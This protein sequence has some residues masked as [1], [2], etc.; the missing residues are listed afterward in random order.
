MANKAE[1]V[2]QNSRD[3]SPNRGNRHSPSFEQTIFV[4]LC[5]VVL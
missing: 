4:D 5:F 3:D 2:S 1:D